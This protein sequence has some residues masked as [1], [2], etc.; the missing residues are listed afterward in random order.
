M[1]VFVAPNDVNDV[2]GFGLPSFFRDLDGCG[3]FVAVSVRNPVLS[4]PGWCK[5][6]A[7]ALEHPAKSLAVIGAAAEGLVLQ[8]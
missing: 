4:W 1:T 2:L 6:L 7:G 5:N 3:G 8:R